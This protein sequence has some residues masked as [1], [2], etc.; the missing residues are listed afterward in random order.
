MVATVAQSGER[1]QRALSAPARAARVCCG[2][3]ANWSLGV[4]A[5]GGIA[6]VESRETVETSTAIIEFNQSGTGWTLG[7]FF[8]PM[9]Q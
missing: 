6:W 7:L 5:R 4:L 3:G 8:N 1:Q 2:R 9:F